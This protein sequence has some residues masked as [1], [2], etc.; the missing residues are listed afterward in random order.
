MRHCLDKK[1]EAFLP[2]ETR[3]NQMKIAGQK[4]ITTGTSES[5][6]YSLYVD[7]IVD[8]CTLRYIHSECCAE[9]I[10]KLL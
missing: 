7:G 8:N 4:S 3:R 5:T 6:P 1:I 9:V 10:F 2:R